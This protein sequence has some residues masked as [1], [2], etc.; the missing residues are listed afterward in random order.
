MDSIIKKGQLS[1]YRGLQM[2]ISEREGTPIKLT[3]KNRNIINQVGLTIKKYL[4]VSKDLLGSKFLSVKDLAPLHLFNPGNVLVICCNDGIIIRY[5]KNRDDKRK[6][7]TGLIDNSLIDMAPIISEAVVFCHSDP[8]FESEIP[9]KG[10]EITVS[11]VKPGNFSKDL[12]KFR[13]GFDVVMSLPSTL[14]SPP[15]KPFCLLSVRNSLEFHLHGEMAGNKA[16]SSYGQRFLIRTQLNLPVGWQCIEIFPFFNLDHW[17]PEFASIW[18]ENDILSSILTKQSQ[19]TEFHN[20]DPNVEARKNYGKIL[21]DYEGLLDSE[22]DREETLQQYLKEYPI[23]LCPTHIKKWPKLKFGAKE[24]DFVFQEAT[25][26]YLLIELEKSIQRLF[27]KNGDTTSELNH[28]RGQLQ[29]WKR[30]IEDNLSTVQRELGLNNLSPNPKC[31]IVMGRSKLLTDENRRKLSV[32]ENESPKLKIMTY[33]DILQN[34][35]T[36][37]EN[38]LGPLWETGGSTTIY[39]L[40]DK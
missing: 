30:Y 38:I 9:T 4:D 28:A 37:I 8:K 34:A 40:T 39:Y 17:K 11:A 6:I 19:E 12:M 3:K 2:Q 5:D 16:S 23:L 25:G 22:P 13:V 35:K 14:P 18:A 32:I 10:I 1:F 20:L 21:K 24:T 27:R 36:V 7:I 29:D 33:D 31:L 26:D 15:R